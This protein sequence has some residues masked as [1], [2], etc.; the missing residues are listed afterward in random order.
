MRV[1]QSL[2]MRFKFI[3]PLCNEVKVLDKN[4]IQIWACCE[5]CVI[6]PVGA[7]LTFNDVPFS[8]FV[9]SLHVSKQ[10]SVRPLKTHPLYTLPKSV[11]GNVC[12]E[13]EFT[14]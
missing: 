2:K 12:E 5:S 9:Y 13:S 11:Y 8:H 6:F 10:S 1:T 14:Y 4:S 3:L 7:K